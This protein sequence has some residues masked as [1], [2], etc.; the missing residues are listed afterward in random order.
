[1]EL[2]KDQK[3]MKAI[4]TLVQHEITPEM[5]AKLWNAE[6]EKSQIEEFYEPIHTHR[7]KLLHRK[8]ASKYACFAYKEKMV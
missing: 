4:I 3:I 5:Y 8:E 6:K 2:L 1:M 7:I